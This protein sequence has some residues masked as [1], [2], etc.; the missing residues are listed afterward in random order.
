[1]SSARRG[2]AGK[3]GKRS[4]SSRASKG[5]AP[6][7]SRKNAKNGT[8]GTGSSSGA[9]KN[10]T[11]KKS[12]TSAVVFDVAPPA[13]RTEPFRLGVVA[14]A[15]PGKW[16]SVW[17]ERYPDI[18]L[19]LVA[20]DPSLARSALLAGD[21]DIA[22]VR[23]PFSHDDLHVIPL[24]EEVVGAIVSIDS[25]LESVAEI[26][27]DDLVGE[28]VIV[29]RDDA[30]HFGPIAGTEAARFAAPATTEEAIETVATGVGVVIVP[31]S[32]ARAHKRKDVTFRPIVGA[33]PTRVGLAWDRAN[34]SV[35]I[36]AFIGIVRGRTAHS[37][38]D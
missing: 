36:Q 34:D 18:D 14:G 7:A 2:P 16:I 10:G 6:R 22:I 4:S 35:D 32:I 9:G 23:E 11:G 29:P 38:R 20:I 5:S 19:E 31:M 30:T 15:T 12:R 24:Y 26:T 33:E 27:L 25:A 1:M 8:K 3:S 28:V 13:A 21:I 37:S 17:R